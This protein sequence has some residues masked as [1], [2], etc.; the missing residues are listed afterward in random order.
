MSIVG[1][2]DIIKGRAPLFLL[3]FLPTHG[4]YQVLKPHVA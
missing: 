4:L 1:N 2:I 3:G